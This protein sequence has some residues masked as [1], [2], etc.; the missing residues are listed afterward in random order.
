MGNVMR[1]DAIKAF[2]SANTHNDLAELY[3]YSMECQVNVAQDD[4]ER[5]EGEYKGKMWHGWTDNLQTWKSFRIPYHANANPH[6]TDK[7]MS[8]SLVD[9]ADGI[10]MTGWDWQNQLSRWVAFD[11]DAMVGHSDKHKKHL[12]A[13]QLTELKTAASTIPWVTLRYST[14]GKG[15]HIYVMLQ[16]VHTINHTEHAGLA[17]SILGLMSAYTGYNFASGV[18]I[19]GGNMWVWHRKMKGTNGLS[20]I[21]HGDC[22]V[23]AP[24]NWKDH[25]K[26]I[27]GKRKKILPSFLEE[28]HS[29]ADHTF[30]ELTG[31]RTQI[32][33][34]EEHLSLIKWL[35]SNNASFWWDQDHWML[36][37]H[38]FDL[39]RAHE[40]L[41]MRGTYKTLSK[42]TESGV[43]HNCY[44]FPLRQGSW[45]VRR[46]SP[47][48]AEASSWDQDEHGYT[49]C[50]LN[51]DPDL[52]EAARSH[53]GLEDEGNTF[54]FRHASFAQDAA[55]SL[56][57][58]LNL[59]SQVV[60]RRA[61]MR[62]HKDGKRLVVE[63]ARQPE[64]SQ[65]DMVNWLPSKRGDIWRRIYNIRTSTIAETEVK[66]YDDVV[67]HLTTEEGADHGWV[68]KSD[69]DW[70]DE[71]LI[72]MRACLDSL[73]LKPPEIRNIIGNSVFRPW[74]IVNRPF[75][76]EY[77]GD[78]C[79]NRH[80]AQFRFAPNLDKDVLT[81]P[82]W[83]LIL[84]HCGTS[85][86][87][88]VQNHPWC[89]T[90]GLKNG[91]DY[92]KCW[93]ASLVQQPLSPL[94]YLFFHGPQNS[95]KSILH[96]A[97]CK[98][99]TSGYT[100]ADASLTSQSGFN[101]ELK[102]SVLCIVEETDLN[103]NK[104]AYN[105]IKDWVTS[106]HLPIRELYRD[107]YLIPNA[108]HWIQCANDRSNCPIFAGDTRVTMSYVP[109]PETEIP[110]A[111]LLD[112]LEKEAPDFL[113]EILRLPLPRPDGRLN[114]PVIQ[115]EDKIA[116]GRINQTLV[117]A[118]IAEHC[119]PIDGS[120]IAVSEL[121]ER[122][123]DWL[124]PGERFGWS[125][126][127]M[128]K[129]MPSIFPKGRSPIDNQWAYG[130]ITFDGTAKLGRTLMTE[131][132]KLVYVT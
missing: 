32:K 68:I 78:R 39:G 50:Y 96:E 35:E 57:A 116:A 80:A 8:F 92:L 109:L 115:T 33:L 123:K 65:N 112:A 63:I 127:R 106:I 69:K 119:F 64:D 31:Q 93:I 38:T 49:R 17:R 58:E 61:T 11:F 29:D 16:P 41:G 26:V 53:D 130:N 82:T 77:P 107:L 114:I 27:S 124:E 9:H 72:H 83:L 46:Y 118:F 22:L 132:E 3:D 79:W 14:S 56:G 97:L 4:G 60:G 76:P 86:D 45:V 18:D 59:P 105:R 101:G 30:E 54:V 73:G 117:E 110:K 24:K 98:L 103:K 108:T 100:R 62:M 87:S 1:T 34:D 7:N 36:V 84:E 47:G 102:N 42:G 128:G 91:S 85:L 13:E 2:L 55:L 121:Y 70:H 113:A 37:A 120:M 10:G 75:Q 43:D 6:Y 131:K 48:V 52:R 5:I 95:G 28:G 88:G 126:I 51:C 20:I 19:C 99:F 15:L 12:T 104:A 90:N 21:K 40:S 25:I 66:N 111:K 122:F 44:L 94:P 125:K 23:S 81:Y 89:I 74:S 129:E 71:P 67:R